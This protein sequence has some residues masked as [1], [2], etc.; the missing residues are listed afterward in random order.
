MQNLSVIQAPMPANKNTPPRRLVMKFGGTSSAG[1]QR[2]AACADL[3]AA[4][5]ADG[6]AIAVTVSAPAGMTDDL[7]AR[8]KAL[9]PDGRWPDETDAVLASGEQINAALLAMTLRKKG[10]K[11]RSFT[12]WQAG[13]MTNG[14]HGAARVGAIEAAPLAALIDGG[15]I[16]V[17]AGFQGLG[18]DGRITTLGRGGS[19]LSAIAL[20]AALEAQECEI[21]TD[22]AGVFSA[23][24]ALVDGARCIARLSYEEMLEMASQGAKVLQTR[25]VELAMAKNIRVRVLSAF[26]ASAQEVGTCIDRRAP[27]EDSSVSAISYS[28]DEARIMLSGL[29][30][31]PHVLGDVF[32]ALAAAGLDVDLIVHSPAQNPGKSN[33]VFSLRR[34]GAD[35][36]CAIIA[37]N[38]HEIGYTDLNLERNMA[39]VSIIGI[40]L[41]SQARMAHTMFNALGDARIDTGGVATSETRISALIGAGDVENAVRV[42]H[43]AFGLGEG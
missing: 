30:A 43:A 20:G 5:Q 35:A 33:L 7:A 37:Q 12:G 42:L 38:R 19:D 32:G 11:A 1:P 14:A 9:D 24:P 40:G 36:A 8:A 3:I 16:A 23:D 29:E 31:G 34:A 25:A 17:I 26:A 15:E 39:K 41:R 27:L 18:P 6:A 13:I 22:V 2:L 21:Y 10:L 4:R 28:R